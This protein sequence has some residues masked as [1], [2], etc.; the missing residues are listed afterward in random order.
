MSELQLIKAPIQTEFKQLNQKSKTVPNGKQIR[1][2]LIFLGKRLLKSNNK[3]ILDIATIIEQIHYAS[4]VHDD[5][6]DESNTRRNKPTYNYKFDNKKA[7]LYGDYLFS[8]ASYQIAL[9]EN[10]EI[11][12]SMSNILVN[13]SLGELNQLDNHYNSN[14]TKEEYIDKTFKKTACM[15]AE[16]MRMCSLLSN[17]DYENVFYNFG[18]DF[19][20]MYQIVDDILDYSDDNNSLKKPVGQDL[21]NGI[22]TLPLISALEH[23]KIQNLYSKYKETKHEIFYELLLRKIRYQHLDESLELLD[24]YKEKCINNLQDFPDDI[25]KESI[26][27]LINY[28]YNKV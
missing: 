6:V 11:S 19:G 7:V 27:S 9:L 3:Q 12:K 26:V 10:T 5:V 23:T 20:M 16:S 13:L 22:I 15:F 25:Y 2:T 18:K 17:K 28:V 1:P 4:I 14:Y 8:N 24:V 21:Q